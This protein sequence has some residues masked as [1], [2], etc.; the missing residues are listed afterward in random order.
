MA[1]IEEIAKD[2]KFNKIKDQLLVLIGRQVKTELKLKK[3]FREICEE[4]SN[5][6]KEMEDV[7]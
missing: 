2:A 4:V 1:C 6:A 5:F 7:V 3:K